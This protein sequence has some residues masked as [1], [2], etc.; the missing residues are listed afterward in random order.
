VTGYL[1]DTM[2]HVAACISLPEKW[3]RQW[4]QAVD[5]TK[6]LLISELLVAEIFYQLTKISG[7]EAARDRIL[8]VKGRPTTT[9]VSID[10]AMSL[11]AGML[12]LRFKNF[13]GIVDAFSLEIAR[14]ERAEIFTTDHQIRKVAKEIGVPVSY[15]PK[16]SLGL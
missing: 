11:N 7:K 6:R 15:L 13:I 2:V 16:E 4:K 12:F 1:F 10:D 5:G 14:R 8:W 9:I 3:R